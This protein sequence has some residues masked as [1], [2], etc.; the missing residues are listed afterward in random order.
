MGYLTTYDAG[1]FEYYEGNDLGSYQFTSLENIINQFQIN[2]VGE[3]KLIPKLKKADV[4]ESKT[5]GRES[6]KYLKGNVEFQK[7]LVNLNY[8][9]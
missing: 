5:I 8:Q 7:G 4:L 3:N 6:V 9:F 1:D 2:Y